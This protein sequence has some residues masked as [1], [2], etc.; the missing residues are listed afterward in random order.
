MKQN[1]S[2]ICSSLLKGLPQRTVTV[3]ERRFGLKDNRETLEGIG[4]DIG[5]TRERVRQIENGGL[6]KIKER[7]S[8]YQSLFKYFNDTLEKFG[9]LKRE[10]ALLEHL[11]GEKDK[12]K[13]SL[14]LAL[15]DDIQKIPEK[16]N[17]YACWAKKDSALEKAQKT[18][19][20]TS[21][22]LKKQGRT[23][24]LDE[25]YGYNEIKEVP[26]KQALESY[27]EVS[28]EIEKKIGRAHV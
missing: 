13:V 1:Y 2:Q 25:I 20:L 23:L 16:D 27:L 26:S 17:F 3:I 18:I 8:K 28:K 19:K 9:G 22:Q 24:S 14:L 15:A 10:D 21:K 11:G 6:S 4:K 12:G 7:S 5:I